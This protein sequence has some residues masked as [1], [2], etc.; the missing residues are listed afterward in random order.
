MK[1]IKD[2]WDQTG[3]TIPVVGPGVGSIGSGSCAADTH[4][5]WEVMRFW[6]AAETHSD[7]TLIGWIGAHQNNHYSGVDVDGVQL[8][9]MLINGYHAAPGFDWSC[10]SW[11][12]PALIH[13]IGTSKPVYG[14]EAGDANHRWIDANGPQPN[15][16]I[17]APLRLHNQATFGRL[18]M[19]L[20]WEFTEVGADD[21]WTGDVLSHSRVSNPMSDDKYVAYKHWCRYIREGATRIE[22]VFDSTGH[23]GYDG[24]NKWD[25]FNSVNI[26]AWANARDQDLTLVVIN[27]RSSSYPLEVKFRNVESSG[28]FDWYLSTPSA[29]WQAQQ[30]PSWNAAT[31]TLSFTIPPYS[32][33]TLVDG[34]TQISE[35]LRE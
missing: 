33:S 7:P 30:H 34:A 5:I 1:V 29:K 27:M 12:P 8:W 10:H 13:G 9:D 11:I 28:V 16:A 2:Y 35:P 23:P 17:T 32:V 22:S 15:S 24:A 20:H 21:Q 4:R 3:T 26:S 18:S 19:S 14:T 6:N 31:K 25:T